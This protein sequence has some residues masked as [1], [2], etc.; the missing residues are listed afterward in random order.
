VHSTDLK[1]V[2][3]LAPDDPPK[4]SFLLYQSDDFQN[5]NPLVQHGI[6]KSKR[7]KGYWQ[8]AAQQKHFFY[9]FVFKEI[10][11]LC[12]NGSRV[13]EGYFPVRIWD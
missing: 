12:H 4:E 10:K 9:V 6:I 1:D 8:L 3:H 2:N 7:Q 5:H 11:D 13:D